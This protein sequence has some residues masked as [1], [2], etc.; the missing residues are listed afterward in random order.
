[1][2]NNILQ[3]QTVY[4]FQMQMQGIPGTGNMGV[5]GGGHYALGGDP[6]DDVSVSP[7]DPAFYAHHGMIDRVWWLWQ[8][9]DPAARVDS[10]AALSGTR[11]FLNLPPSAN[12]TL[13]DYAEYGYAA[14][15]PR[16]LRE[17]MSTT[18]GPFC[19]VYQ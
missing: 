16:R 6:A 7:G 2:K 10:D 17:L 18:G 14:G 13:D 5:H 1:M 12:A 9:Q 8:M 4:D 19:Y 11:T 3:P 15:P